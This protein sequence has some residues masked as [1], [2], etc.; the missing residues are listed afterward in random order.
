[1]KFLVKFDKNWADECDVYGFKIMTEEQVEGLRASLPYITYYFGSNEGWEEPGEFEERDFTIEPLPDFKE[2]IL[3][4][5]FPMNSYND[6]WGNF[7][8]YMDALHGKVWEWNDQGF[9]D[10]PDDEV[11]NI[12]SL[13]GFKPETADAMDAVRAYLKQNS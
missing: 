5:L 1:M 9:V 10:M 12:F 13:L 11:F 8:D 4:Q 3:R 7:P 2:Q 6:S